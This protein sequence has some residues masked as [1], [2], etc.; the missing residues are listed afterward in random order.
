MLRSSWENDAT[1]LAM[2]SGYTWNHAHADA[3][4]FILFKQGEPLIIDSGTC[5]L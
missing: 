4:S 5:D 2:K 1:L 3:G